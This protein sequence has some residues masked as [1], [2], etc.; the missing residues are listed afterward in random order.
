MSEH[1]PES[2]ASIEARPHISNHRPFIAEVL[3][4]AGLRKVIADNKELAIAEFCEDCAGTCWVDDKLVFWLCDG[5][6][7]GLVLPRLPEVAEEPGTPS[8]F[9]FSPRVLAQDLGENF[10][11]HLCPML[12]KQESPQ[13]SAIDLSLPDTVFS[14][15][16]RIWEQRLADYVSRLEARNLRE[17]LLEAFHLAADNTY[18]A[19]WSATFTG[20]VFQPREERLDIVNYGYS[21]ALLMTKPPTVIAPNTQMVTLWAWLEPA[22]SLIAHTLIAVEPGLEWKSATG[23]EGFAVM[24]DGLVRGDLADRL[25]RFQEQRYGSLVELRTELL[26]GTDLTWDDKSIIFGRFQGV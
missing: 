10:V 19:A 13:V 4:S 24:S 12:L 1:L 26:H 14:N 20:G 16:A 23:V 21:G 6:S 8:V 3:V 18:R 2:D 25:Q 15:V 7:E 5:A 17:E 11:Q 22:E 9:G